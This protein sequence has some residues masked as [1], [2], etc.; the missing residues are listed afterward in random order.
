MTDDT[1]TRSLDA[2][3]LESAVGLWL[4]L[5]QQQDLRL[6]NRAFAAAGVTQLTYSMLL[7]IG[8]MPGC[9]QTDLSLAL[10]IRQPNL[11]E[12]IESLMSRGLVSRRP[13]PAD[14][15]AQTLSLTDQGRALVERLRETHAALIGGYRQ[16]MG[17]E[18]YDQLIELLRRFLGPDQGA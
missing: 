14:R 18:A 10:R 7:L 15:R 9:R 6:F 16:K 3:E 17:P 13:D 1:K 4:R 12:P 8:D 5:A 2:S 11:V